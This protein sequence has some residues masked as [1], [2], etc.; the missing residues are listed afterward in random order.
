MLKKFFLL[1][2][3]LGFAVQAFAAEPEKIT[4]D[5]QNGSNY[6]GMV[7]MQEMFWDSVAKEQGIKTKLELN[8]VGGPGAAAERFL[9]GAN[10]G[11][12]ISYP[13]I[14]TLHEKTKGDAKILF[15]NAVLDILLNVNNPNIKTTKDLKDGQKIAVTT[16]NTSIQAI[17]MRALSE[18]LYKDY[19]K[20]DSITVQMSHPD[21]FAAL[22]AE[23][24]DG[25]WAT[26]PFSFN[27]LQNQ[28]IKTIAKSSE[29]FGPASLTAFVTSERFCKANPKVCD[30]LFIA[31]TKAVEWINQDFDRA[32]GYFE[33]NVGTKDP[34]AEYLRQ[35]KDKDIVFTVAP[36]GIQSYANYVHKFG[37]IQTPIKSWKEV[38]LPQLQNNAEAN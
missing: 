19:K 21:A 17:N 8:K 22:M 31:Y 26:P 32:A 6:M 25:H 24:I 10:Q 27:E 5:I 33:K 2:V 35:F 20:L 36:K 15:G 7:I 38:V 13:L 11:M 14:L 34:K 4:L 37:L 30:S 28:K 18:K 23:K 12:T 16:L 1:A 29:I 9:S 3:S